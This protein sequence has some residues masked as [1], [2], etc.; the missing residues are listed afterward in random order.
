M[1]KFN[2]KYYWEKEK[3][4]N[5][6]DKYPPIMYSK[7]KITETLDNACLGGSFY[8]PEANWFLVR[9]NLCEEH[10][11]L[12]D[13]QTENIN[14]FN[15]RLIKPFVTNL[16]IYTDENNYNKIYLTFKN[17]NS[18]IIKIAAILIFEKD[19]IYLI[20]NIGSDSF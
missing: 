14:V 9:K 10:K 7:T 17:K 15:G 18:N 12:W 3:Y 8:K 1:I 2:P 6:V 16:H 5:E 11:F 13:I 4:F 20:E 19:V